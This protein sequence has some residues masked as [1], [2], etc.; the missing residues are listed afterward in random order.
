MFYDFSEQESLSQRQERSRSRKNVTPLTS[1]PSQKALGSV[2]VIQ[3]GRP[4]ATE[5]QAIVF[6][7]RSL[8][9]CRRR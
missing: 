7:L 5:R 8:C 2:S 6:L 4:P 1:G 9:P 3:C